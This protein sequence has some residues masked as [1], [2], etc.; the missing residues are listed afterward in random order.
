MKDFFKGALTVLVALAVAA[1]IGFNVAAIAQ[2]QFR[3]MPEA[4]GAFSSLVRI[5][6]TY[7]N[8]NSL[9]A[10][11]AESQTVPT[12]ARWVLFSAACNFY[13]NP[14]TTATVPGDVTNGSASELN[15]SSWY[16]ADVATISVI[17]PTACVITFAF[18]K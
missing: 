15:P 2:N 3:L 13:A 4:G 12:G 17:A 16:V 14:T 10:S 5:A 8:A 6:P 11:V 7:V 18:Y 9:A 1:T